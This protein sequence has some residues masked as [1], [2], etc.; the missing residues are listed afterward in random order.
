MAYHLHPP[1][2]GRCYLSRIHVRKL[3]SE[4]IFRALVSHRASS[5]LHGDLVSLHQQVI[6]RSQQIC[7]LERRI[8][9]ATRRRD[10]RRLALARRT[11]G[12]L[13]AKVYLAIT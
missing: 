3:R 9:G 5:R 2:M 7:Q 4:K 10:G 8:R 11:P 12:D 13:V 6:P 1:N